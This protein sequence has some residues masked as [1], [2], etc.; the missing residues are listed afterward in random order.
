MTVFAKP[1][2][3]IH[4]Q[5]RQ[6]AWLRR[7]SRLW[8]CQ[9]WFAD[10]R[11]N[12][13]ITCVQ[14]LLAASGVSGV[15]ARLVAAQVAALQR[16]LAAPPALL[17]LLG[18][19]DSIASQPVP[20]PIACRRLNPSSFGTVRA[21]AAMLRVA[22][23]EAPAVRFSAVEVSAATAAGNARVALLNSPTESAAADAHG[24]SLSAGAWL[25]PRLA[26]RRQ[27]AAESS[28]AGGGSEASFTAPAGRIMVTGQP[29][30]VSIV[31]PKLNQT[32]HLL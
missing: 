22:S 11:R 19:G 28:S 15:G 13:C 24:Q 27:E 2:M 23:V 9:L 14:D 21:L 10:L 4:Q 18:I 3:G 29:F 31:L 8:S 1:A 12:G 25:A 5:R 17:R 32:R 7:K 30:S 26:E 6:P 16:R 20:A